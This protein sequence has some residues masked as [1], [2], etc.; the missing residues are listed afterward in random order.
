[1]DAVAA[2]PFST[3]DFRMRAARERMPHAGTTMATTR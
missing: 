3:D 1:M 2:K